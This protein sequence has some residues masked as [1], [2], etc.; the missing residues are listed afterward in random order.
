MC[1][2]KGSLFIVVSS[3]KCLGLIKLP[4]VVARVSGILST[5]S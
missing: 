4:D 2:E 3:M 1:N 5:L